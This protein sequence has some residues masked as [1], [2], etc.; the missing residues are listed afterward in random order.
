MLKTL[1]VNGCRVLFVTVAS[2][3]AFIYPEI[4]QK[5]DRGQSILEIIRKSA[6]ISVDNLAE[7]VFYEGHRDAWWIGKAQRSTEISLAYLRW[8]RWHMQLC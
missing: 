4:N 2:S 7:M 8:L 5:A 3:A 1:G 6:G